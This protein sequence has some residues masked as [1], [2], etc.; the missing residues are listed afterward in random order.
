M[1]KLRQLLYTKPIP[2]EAEIVTHKGKPHARFKNRR[3]K[4]VL[5][6][7]ADN[8]QRIRLWS[9]KWYGEYRDANGVEQCVP[10]STNKTA[11]QQML[12]EL[13][14]QAELGRIGILDPYQEHRKRPLTEHLDDFRRYLQA[15]N[16]DPRYVSQVFAHCQALFDGT[17]ARLMDDLDAGKIAEWLAEQRRSAGM[18]ISTSNHYLT[19][20]KGFSKWLVKPGNRVGNDRL[21]ILSRLNAET[22]IRR[23]RRDL[24]ADGA[25]RLLE[26]ALISDRDFRDLTAEDRYF[27]YAVAF[28]TG[29]RA[30]ELASLTKTSFALNADPPTITLAAGYSKRRREDVQPLPAELAEALRPYLDGKPADKPVWPGTRHKRAYKMIARDLEAARQAGIKE[31]GDN[32]A[33][34]QQREHSSYLAYRDESGRVFDFH[35]TRHSYITLLT[36]SGVHPKMAQSLARHGTIGQTMDC[37]THVGLQDQA[38]A[39]KALPSILSARPNRGCSL[40]AQT[41]LHCPLT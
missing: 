15:K 9:R 38:A 12:H 39:L 14:R 25:V 1:A 34:R 21:A 5:A 29:L 26:A 24:S 6:P 3:G 17:C 7:L 41:G 20:A 33:E 35:G 27:L 16:N 8:G 2:S 18:S 11:A 10:L 32:L 4:A 37:Y 36:K 22:D 19:S 13:V 30:S 28:Q 40:V 23:K 31:A